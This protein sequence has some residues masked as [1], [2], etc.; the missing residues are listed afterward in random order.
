MSAYNLSDCFFINEIAGRILHISSTSSLLL[1]KFSTNIVVLYIVFAYYSAL[2]KIKFHIFSP[3]LLAF[4]NITI[5]I[6]EYQLQK[7][8]KRF[9]NFE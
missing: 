3:H 8:Y 4:I 2:F 6:F 1:Q 7:V 9:I 5:S